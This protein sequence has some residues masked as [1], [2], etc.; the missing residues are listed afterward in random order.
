M[1]SKK[2]LLKVLSVVFVVFLLLMTLSSCKK[3]ES[4]DKLAANQ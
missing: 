2:N 1:K 4:E 3:K